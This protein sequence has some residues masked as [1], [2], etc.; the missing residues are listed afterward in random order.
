MGHFYGA[1]YEIWAGLGRVGKGGFMS[2]S[3]G[4]FFHCPKNVP[5]TILEL[6]HPVH[7]ID[8]MPLVNFFAFS[9]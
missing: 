6:I 7:D 2:E 9:H 5:K 3:T 1:E 4:E 8:K